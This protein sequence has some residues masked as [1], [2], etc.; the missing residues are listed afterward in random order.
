[1]S[2]WKNDNENN[3]SGNIM[4]IKSGELK[5]DPT[6]TPRTQTA[7]IDNFSQVLLRQIS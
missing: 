1:M 3:A 4:R 7:E 5:V 2:T 6:Q